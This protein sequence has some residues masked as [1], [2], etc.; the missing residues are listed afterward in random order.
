MKG[1][2][3][4]EWKGKNVHNW[5]NISH[6]SKVHY[7]TR[8]KW[9]HPMIN[10]LE[11]M[12]L[13][14]LHCFS[15]VWMCI[16]SFKFE[17]QRGNIR[18]KIAKAGETAALNMGRLERTHAKSKGRAKL[19]F[20]RKASLTQPCYDVEG[21]VFF[22]PSCPIRATQRG[23]LHHIIRPSS[24]RSQYPISNCQLSIGNGQ[25]TWQLVGPTLS[26]SASSFCSSSSPS[27]TVSFPLSP[28]VRVE[29]S[30][31]ESIQRHKWISC[32]VLHSCLLFIWVSWFF[33]RW[34]CLLDQL[35]NVTLISITMGQRGVYSHTVIQFALIQLPQ[36]Q[37]S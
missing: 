33:S 30:S 37:T 16:H 11:L 23:Q 25:V 24:E 14:F 19:G 12:V 15:S 1:P 9:N 35:I 5:W 32:D 27:S 29:E 36:Q 22:K 18:L 31:S 8:V 2:S 4:S 13:H 26:P 20:F 3:I 34:N 6:E 21:E 17:S 7:C 28:A 10:L